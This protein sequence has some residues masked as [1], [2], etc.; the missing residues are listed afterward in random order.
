M[1]Q[2]KLLLDENISPAV[3]A[4]LR[5]DGYNAASIAEELPGMEDAAVLRKAQ[6]EERIVVTLDRDFGALIFRDSNR[7]VGV[8]FLRLKK[9]SSKNVYAAITSVLVQYGEE[10]EQKFTTASEWHVRMKE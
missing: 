7:H 8:L 9:E 3:A 10:L 2:P 1:A 6:R 5:K 4:R